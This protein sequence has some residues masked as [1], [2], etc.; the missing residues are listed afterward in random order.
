MNWRAWQMSS[1]I[2]LV[3]DN[4]DHA[5]IIKQLLGGDEVEKEIYWAKDGQEALDFVHHTGAHANA[6][7]PSLIILDLN[8]PKASGM[9]VLKELKEDNDLKV[10]PV[11]MLTTSDRNEEMLKCYRLGANSFITKP[12]RFDD[13]MEKLQSLE[14]YWLH[15]NREPQYDRA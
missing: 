13:Y 5:E 10:I 1:V 9:D 4:E 3:E 12:A 7:R 6:P 15:T 2:L 14:R 8:L 11:V